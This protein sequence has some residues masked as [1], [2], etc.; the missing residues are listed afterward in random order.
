MVGKYF[1]VPQN[2]VRRSTQLALG[3]RRRVNPPGIRL[4]LGSADNIHCDRVGE[5]WSVTLTLFP[6]IMG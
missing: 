1:E 3:S 4:F 6:L 5:L 2:S